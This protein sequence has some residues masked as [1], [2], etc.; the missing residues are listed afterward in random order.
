MKYYENNRNKTTNLIQVKDKDNSIGKLTTSSPVIPDSITSLQFSTYSL[1]KE[2]IT[3][4]KSNK[5]CISNLPNA[6]K[7]CDL[8]RSY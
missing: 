2:P 1:S 3:I 8:P 4:E 5:N 6:Q 7:V